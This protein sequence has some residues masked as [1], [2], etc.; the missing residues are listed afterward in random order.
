MLPKCE[1]LEAGLGSCVLPVPSSTTYVSFYNVQ[2]LHRAYNMFGVWIYLSHV[3]TSHITYK[4][5]CYTVNLGTPHDHANF[6][7]YRDD[8]GANQQ[9]TYNAS[10]T[11][12]NKL[13]CFF[14]VDEILQEIPSYNTE[15]ME[16]LIFSAS[17]FS[18]ETCPL[19]GE[20]VTQ[21]L[22]EYHYSVVPEHLLGDAIFTY[23]SITC[24]IFVPLN[25]FICTLVEPD[26]LSAVIHG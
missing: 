18:T 26:C 24:V 1:S 4:W 20:H 12:L 14:Y 5:N 9:G 7:Y 10:E 3:G 11:L 15:K 2:Q 25:S 23:F 22:P 6:F 19:P 8:M 21:I 13:R 16:R 17:A